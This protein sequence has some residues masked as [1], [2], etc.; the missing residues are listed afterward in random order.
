LQDVGKYP[1]EPDITLEGLKQVS[2]TTNNTKAKG[3]GIIHTSPPEWLV[4]ILGGRKPCIGFKYFSI[5]EI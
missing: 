1:S 2:A 3:T 4:P 5:Q